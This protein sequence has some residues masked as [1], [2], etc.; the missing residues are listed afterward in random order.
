MPARHFVRL[1]GF[2]KS[3]IVG[4]IFVLV[5]LVLL[6]IVIGEAVRVAYQVVHPLLQWLPFTS[7]STIALASGVSVIALVLGCFVA[8][9]LA[10]TALSQWFVGSLERLIL[11]FVPSYGLIKNMSQGWLGMKDDGQHQSVLVRLDDATQIGFLMDTLADGR[12]AVFVPDVPTPW[13]GSLIFVTADRIEPLPLSTK[14]TIECLHRLGANASQLL[15]T[16]PGT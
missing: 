1:F 5:P 9:L 11:S 12:H 8:G 15:A 7:A 3:T 13:S 2:V 4:G 6:S 14:Q 10:R 16:P